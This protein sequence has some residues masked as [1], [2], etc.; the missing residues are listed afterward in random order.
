MSLEPDWL[1]RLRA[2]FGAHE[3]PK[4]TEHEIDRATQRGW[5]SLAILGVWVLFIALGDRPSA[6]RIA[7]MAFLGLY[8]F[9]SFA[10]RRYIRTNANSGVALQ[11]LFLVADPLALVLVLFEDAEHFA[12]LSPFLLV[13]VVRCGIRYGTRVMWLAWTVTCAAAG[14]LLPLNQYWRRETELALSFALTLVFVPVFFPTLI[15]RVH[16]VRAIE[17]ERARLKAIQEG[18]NARNNFLARVSHELRSPLQSIVSALDVF[19]ARHGHAIEGDDELIARMRRS[20]MLLNAQVGDLLTLARG[21]AGSLE[22]HP[23]PLEVTSLMEGVQLATRDAAA[24]KGLRLELQCPPEALFVVADG[25]RIDQ[26][27]TNLVV[28]SIRYTENGWVQI[29]LHAYDAENTCL[30]FTISDSGCG[31]PADRLQNLFA[32]DRFLLSADRRGEGFGIGLAVVRTLVDRLGG[33]I[34]A[35]SQAGRGT[36]FELQIPAERIDSAE[37]APASVSEGSACR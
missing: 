13:V 28:N 23:E 12:F 35:E 30:R 15:R 21:Q 20:S 7:L 19:E 26:V 9:A 24:E 2:Y 25:A 17:E 18:V 14:V 31:M 1:R 3:V 4:R 37:A 34:S 8:S 16:Q 11:Y 33:T 6:L 29:K 5:A 32:P 36:T 27:L 22:L 10:Y